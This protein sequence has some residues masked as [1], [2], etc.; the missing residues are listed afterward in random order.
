[1]NGVKEDKYILRLTQTAK[2]VFYVDK[3]GCEGDNIEGLVED[4]TAL[5]MKAKLLLE[6]L[7]EVK[8]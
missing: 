1:M 8:E 6:K 2:G 3:V 7:N 5:V 4:V